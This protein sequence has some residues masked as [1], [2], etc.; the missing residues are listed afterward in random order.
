MSKVG[1]I[2]RREWLELRKERSLLATMIVFPLL[3]TALGVGVTFGLGLVPDEEPATLGAALADP[4]LA[5]LPL[6]QLGQ[7]IM[8]R[9]FSTLLLLLPLFLSG[10]IAAQSIVGEKVGRTLEPLLATPVRTWELLL[11]KSLIAL[12]P[13][14][15]LTWAAATAFGVGITLVA[16]TPEVARLIVSPAWILLLL[17]CS[18]LLGLI[19]VAASVLISARVNDPRTAQNLTSVVVIPIL[20]LFVGQLFGLVVLSLGLVLALAAALCAVAALTLW[21]AVRMFQREV[22]LTRWV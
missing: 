21:L 17:L 2:M 12:A 6:D 5:G 1:V 15:A 7:V 8:G 9:Q 19:M 20:L 11:A 14:I 16:L 3:I 10:M 4:A 13:T 18:P 22:I